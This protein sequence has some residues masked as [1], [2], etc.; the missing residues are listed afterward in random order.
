MGNFRGNATRSRGTSKDV[1]NARQWLDTK[2]IHVERTL[3]EQRV[4]PH[5][6]HLSPRRDT[7]SNNA[8]SRGEIRRVVLAGNVNQVQAHASSETLSRKLSQKVQ[9]W[10]RRTA[11]FC[12]T[13][14]HRFRIHQNDDSSA[15]VS[16]TPEHPSDG[17]KKAMHF[18]DARM[19]R[20]PCAH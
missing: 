15:L 12:G 1:A 2:L 4:P 16:R 10:S 20:S 6:K 9:P 5:T 13:A 8:F 11:A 18:K 7:P 3:A 14:K 19:I 17:H